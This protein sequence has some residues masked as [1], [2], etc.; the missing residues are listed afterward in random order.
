MGVG[1]AVIQYQEVWTP[2]TEVQGMYE[3]PLPGWS[4][5]ARAEEG[6]DHRIGIPKNRLAVNSSSLWAR[7]DKEYN[8]KQ[9]MKLSWIGS[10]KWATLHPSRYHIY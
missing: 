9:I 4:M 3:R 6:G 8:R 2:R 7:L 1:N 10:T 5:V